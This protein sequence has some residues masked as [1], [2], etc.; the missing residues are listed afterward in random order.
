MASRDAADLPGRKRRRRSGPA[1]HTGF[2][3]HSRLRVI[4]SVLAIVSAALGANPPT[5]AQS[6]PS[7]EM[8]EKMAT[9]HE[10]MAECL[11]SDKSITECRTAMMKS[12]HDVVGND[13]CSM[14]GMGRGAHHHMMQTAAANPENQN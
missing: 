11:R 2:S 1:A 9:L 6:D 5:G 10:K 3:P 12:C 8:R 7:K 4:A 13:D 14:M